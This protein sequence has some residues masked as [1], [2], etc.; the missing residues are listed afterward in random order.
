MGRPSL[1]I[2]T[3]GSI[4]VTSAGPGR[5]RARCRF[6]DYD[7][8]TRPVERYGKSKQDARG[9]L[10]D[11]LKDRKHIDQAAEI[12]PDT[13]VKDVAELWYSDVQR[14]VDAGERSPGSTRVYRI[15]LD[16]Q[17]LPVLG[18][19]RVREVTVGRV[20]GL[21]KAVTK[22]N[23]ASAA[24]TVRTVV[25][26]VMGLAV[27]H[28]ALEA[29]PAR[30]AAPVVGAAPQR[31]PRALMLA[32]IAELRGKLVADEVACRRDLPEL[33]DFM[34]ATGLR[35]GE[36]CAV[37]WDSLNLAEGTVEV[38]GTVIRIKG[39]GLVI[40]PKPKSK[41]GYRT[42]E[43]P[44]WA[45]RLLEGRQLVHDPNEWGV[46]FTAPM[47]G[48]RDPSNTNADLRDTLDREVRDDEGN[49]KWPVFDW[50]TS[51]VFRK[52]VATLMDLAALPARAAADQLGHSKVS[53][54]QDRYYGRKVAKT[55]AAAVLEGIVSAE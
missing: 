21:I 12:T 28:D 29:N 2:G 40:K 32:E 42:L 8:V 30:D 19:L 18:G 35:I 26:G 13:L 27:R 14:L 39:Q 50:V 48:L 17:I 38:R 20:D 11:A 10:N 3:A 7:G 51:H 44:S 1:P 41:S 34:L 46:V 47:G 54:T 16:N 6:R 49:L 52:T 36:A 55:G 9:R 23:G 25:S 45:V 31:E 37:T 53:M 4:T 43:L 24:K 15:Y 5:F 22:S 33:V